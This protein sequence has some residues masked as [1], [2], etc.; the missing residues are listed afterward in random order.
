METSCDNV[1]VIKRSWDDRCEYELPC[2][3]CG[4]TIR[5]A[6]PPRLARSLV[7]A[8]ASMT[9]A[10]ANDAPAVTMMEVLEMRRAL[11]APGATERVWA[12][13]VG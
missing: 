3:E 1:T 6:L 7:A 12:E 4:G 11:D 10:D 2:P 9:V 5:H 8:G 13:L